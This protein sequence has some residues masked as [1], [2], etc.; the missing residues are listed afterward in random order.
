M[1]N[2]AGDAAAAATSTAVVSTTGRGSG[3]ISPPAIAGEVGGGRG[4][5]EIGQDLSISR[6]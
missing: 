5:D 3:G 2:T 1:V 6:G 4:R